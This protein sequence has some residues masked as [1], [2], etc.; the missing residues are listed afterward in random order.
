MKRIAVS[1][2]IAAALL[3]VII[4]VTG[5]LI[6]IAVHRLATATPRQ[7]K[8]YSIRVVAYEAPKVVATPSGVAYLF[9]LYV[10]A[11]DPPI[12]VDRVYLVL[13]ATGTSLYATKILNGPVKL[14]PG[15]I[16]KVS[17]LVPKA[18]FES[19]ASRYSEIAI[20]LGSTSGIVTEAVTLP[21]SVLSSIPPEI[22]ALA[23]FKFVVI[24]CSDARSWWVNA[25]KIVDLIRNVL[26]KYYY[27]KLVIIN[28][29]EQLLQFIENPANF[30]GMNLTG[31]IVINAHGEVVPIPSEF[32]VNG[33]PLW[34]DWYGNITN[35]IAKYR[36]I[37]VSVV[38]YPFFYVS[39]TLYTNWKPQNKPSG[40]YEVG[41]QG[42][43]YVLEDSSANA[44]SGDEWRIM[45]GG[46]SYHD[47]KDNSISLTLTSLGSRVAMLYRYLFGASIPSTI[48]CARAIKS[49]VTPNAIVY[50]NPSSTIRVR[51]LVTHDDF[52]ADTL[53]PASVN[54]PG[55]GYWN[56]SGSYV[57][58]SST[59]Y[60]YSGSAV[61]RS[62]LGWA[63]L[64]NAHQID[65]EH[66]YVYVFNLSISPSASSSFNYVIN[67]SVPNNLGY[68]LHQIIIEARNINVPSTP[69]GFIALEKLGSDFVEIP[70]HWSC[71]SSSCS[72]L[73]RLPTL[74]ASGTYVLVV[75]L[76]TYVNY[77]LEEVF[78]GYATF[79]TAS[80]ASMDWML[81]GSATVVNGHLQ[82]VPEALGEV[83]RAWLKMPIPRDV[84]H[85]VINFSYEF[86]DEVDSRADG[87]VV[88]FFVNSTTVTS[89]NVN[90]GGYEGFGNAVGYAIEFDLYQND[91]DPSAPHVALIN[92]SV[93]NHIV[94]NSSATLAFVANE[95][96]N[97]S[98][99]IDVDKGVEVYVDNNLVLKYSGRISPLGSY[100]FFAAATGGAYDGVLI[101][102]VS[103]Y[104]DLIS[105]PSTSIKVLSVSGSIN[106]GCSQVDTYIK[107]LSDGE[108]SRNGVGL[109][110]GSLALGS[111]SYPIAY[112]Y[113]YAR[114][115][116][117]L[118]SLS[119]GTVLRIDA[120]PVNLRPST[121]SNVTISV[122]STG[123]DVYVDEVKV[124]SSSIDVSGRPTLAIYSE[125]ATTGIGSVDV[126]LYYREFAGPRYCGVIYRIG[127]GY[128]VLNTWSPPDG[129]KK[130]YGY[131]YSGISEDFVAK[132]SI[133]VPV[134][135]VLYKSS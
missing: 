28:N 69:A 84:T 74:P 52:D 32:V 120:E 47:F 71:S 58:K 9:T 129:V 114:S 94:Y 128:L 100:L 105:I 135:F 124:L 109:C 123:I 115:L 96:H 95:W 112:A 66:R 104:G 63:D 43:S 54:P 75:P 101:D 55:Y 73:A 121:F 83:G 86:V 20:A 8:L 68:D 51:E 50:T 44:W 22:R 26:S 70:L 117:A 36:L 65:S 91:Y 99:V 131:S 64:I 21:Q 25:S 41:T 56:Y 111:N 45:I 3:I 6:Y 85:L 31:A 13:P 107:R 5:V 80:E 57:V 78:L 89:V 122:S 81:A 59:L 49:S 15:A 17:F 92:S 67:I 2:V 42:L 11:F 27:V 7:F 127:S 90:G 10:Q 119:K 33:V 113:T 4:V 40:V 16:V 77:P 82:L 61:N 35:A 1:P 116:E 34:K 23:G 46:T 125:N 29:T 76:N 37:W 134:E 14:E 98:I 38:G 103:I 48:R 53:N 87:F 130:E 97:C 110:V 88:A 133:V 30:S 132:M 108:P 106:L 72:F 24:N 18:V 102:N 62:Y 79:D 126:Y 19:I 60:L 118:L 12:L 93:T 39:N